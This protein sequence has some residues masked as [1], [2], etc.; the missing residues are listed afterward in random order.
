MKI[1]TPFVATCIAFISLAQPGSWIVFERCWDDYITQ[2]THE[3]AM[4]VYEQLPNEVLNKG[5]PG[6]RLINKMY[7]SWPHVSKKIVSGNEDAVGIG[8]KLYAIVDGGFKEDV[9]ADLGKLIT[10]NAKLFLQELKKHRQLVQN[11]DGIVCNYGEA[12]VDQKEL[13][14]E[15]TDR[16]MRL[17]VNV[18][19]PDLEDMKSECLKAL[20]NKK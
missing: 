8:F 3:N 20:M 11:L 7:E 4:K 5:L 14:M 2:P 12:Y 17:L 15:E 18:N 16:R 10:I 1:L 13:Q 19:D 9:G 6:E